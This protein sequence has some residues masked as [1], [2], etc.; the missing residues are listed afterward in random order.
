[1]N[2]L[3]IKAKIMPRIRLPKPTIGNFG[4]VPII[5]LPLASE[6]ICPCIFSAVR[7]ALKYVIREMTP[8]RKNNTPIAMVIHVTVCS[9]YWMSKTPMMMAQ[10]ARNKELCTTFIIIFFKMILQCNINLYAKIRKK[11]EKACFL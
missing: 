8:D 3:G 11:I 4:V 9:R 2:T 5:C 7:L 1:M 6:S 10:T